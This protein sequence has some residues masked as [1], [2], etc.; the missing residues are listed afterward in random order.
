MGSLEFNRA[1]HCVVRTCEESHVHACGTTDILARAALARAAVKQLSLAR[2]RWSVSRVLSPSGPLLPRL[3]SWGQVPG[4]LGP[5]TPG[6]LPCWKC[7]P[8]CI[9]PFGILHIGCCSPAETQVIS[10]R[11][12]S[13]GNGG[14]RSHSHRTR[15][16]GHVRW[17][18]FVFHHVGRVSPAAH[19][20]LA[21]TGSDRPASGRP[22]DVHH[23]F[24]W[25]R[26]G[27]AGL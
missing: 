12:S 15:S 9:V 6:I 11:L 21:R 23:P 10:R 1:L 25:W 7:V 24:G 5:S 3:S 17:W 26:R 22:R 13:V 2:I 27:R 14:R 4:T 18:T 19:G 20:R 8:V 16:A